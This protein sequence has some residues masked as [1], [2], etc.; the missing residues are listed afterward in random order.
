MTIFH[1]YILRPHYFVKCWGKKHNSEQGHC[2]LGTHRLVEK[3]QVDNHSDKVYD[4]CYD[5]KKKIKMLRGAPELEWVEG[6]IR[7]GF[8]V[9]VATAATAKL[10]S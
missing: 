5:R 2:T 7:D 1:K 4:G 3:V 6:R 8:L 10:S 9:E